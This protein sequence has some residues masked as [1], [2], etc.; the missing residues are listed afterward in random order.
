MAMELL[1]EAV[2][3]RSENSDAEELFRVAIEHANRL[4]PSN[5]DRTSLNF[6]P[7]RRLSSR[8]TSEETLPRW[9]TSGLSHLSIFT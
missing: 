2:S 1:T 7:W 6:R 5:G 3:N 8:F 4:Y 9:P